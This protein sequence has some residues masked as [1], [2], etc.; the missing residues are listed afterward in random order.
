ADTDL[1]VDSPWAKSVLDIHPNQQTRDLISS[2][3]SQKVE[4]EGPEVESSLPMVANAPEL[5]STHTNLNSDLE[6]QLLNEAIRK[7]EEMKSRR[8][9]VEKE[10]SEILPKESS[11]VLSMASIFGPGN[12]EDHLLPPETEHIPNVDQSQSPGPDQKLAAGTAWL[13]VEQ[14]YLMFYDSCGRRSRS[15]AANR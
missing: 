1:E 8:N 5:L 3:C 6:V 12:L 14:L 10:V 7:K 4:P 13:V 2:I 11:A 15:A 9:A